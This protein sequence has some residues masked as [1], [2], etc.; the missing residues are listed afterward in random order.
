MWLCISAPLRSQEEEPMKE[1]PAVEQESD[2]AASIKPR[3]KRFKLKLPP[4]VQ[5]M[6]EALLRGEKKVVEAVFRPLEFREPIATI[7][8]EGRFG[9]G[10]YGWDG[11]NFLKISPSMISYEEGTEDQISEIGIS[12]RMGSFLEMEGAQTN[13]AYAL[14]GKSYTDILTGIGLRYSSIFPFPRME[15]RD[16]LIITG[17]PDV[18]EAWE[19]ERK[20]SPAVLE[21]NLVS[22][23][24]MRWH[25]KWFVHLKYSYG[26]NYTRFLKGERMDSSPYGTGTSSAY[27]V[28]LKLITESATEARYAWGLELRHIYHKVK[29]IT[30]P[31]ELTPITGLRLPN[32]GLFFTFSAFYGGRTTVGDEGKKLFLN[33]DYVAARPKFLQFMNA[34]PNHARIRRARKLLDITNKRIP[35][36][37][38]TEGGGLQGRRR[39]DDA[40]EKYVEAMKTAEDTLKDRLEEKLDELVAYYIEQGNELFDLRRDEEALEN[41]RKAAALTDAGKRALDRLHAKML[42]VQGDDLAASGLYHMAIRKYEAAPELDRT[43]TVAARRASLQ[44]AVGMVGDVNQATDVAS[45]RLALKSL[46]TARDMFAPAEFKYNDYIARLEEQLAAADSVQVRREMDDSLLKAREIIAQRHMPRLELGM[47]VSE[48]EDLLGEP[49]EIV[50]TPGDQ[51]RNYQMWIYNLSRT[52][53]KLLYFEDYI[54][55]KI[56]AG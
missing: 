38:Y 9:V 2:E 26:V 43:L 23:Y 30:D 52:E 11:L 6:A 39:M 17:P 53:K 10:F 41:L 47:L 46:K 12:G 1:T 42:M 25:P 56:E 3:R 48:V 37:L 45:L 24:I 4:A 19:I 15:I 34:H 35:Y 32:L 50:E 21:L 8:A 51:D 33:E 27:S 28:G 44:A 36:Q 49:D 40:A 13:P 18:P 20:F 22:S 16:D 14:F 54:L 7:P 29:T 55:F 5:Q 31:S